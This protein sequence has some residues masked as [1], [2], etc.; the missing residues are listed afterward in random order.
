MA[1]L[2][3]KLGGHE[4]SRHELTKKE[5][6]IGR[7]HECDVVIDNPAISRVHAIVRNH[8]H[9]CSIEDAGLSRN[10]LYHQGKLVREELRFHD[11]VEV[12]I[13][14]YTLAFSAEGKVH[15]PDSIPPEARLRKANSQNP[16]PTM[17]MKYVPYVTARPPKSRTKSA[18]LGWLLWAFWVALLAGFL[19]VLWRSLSGR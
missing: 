12:V 3:V 13:G 9:W 7:A 17:Q 16:F 8:G 14:K 11:D 5:T 19:V 1:W 4:L 10:G 18:T 15:E 6:T 2:I